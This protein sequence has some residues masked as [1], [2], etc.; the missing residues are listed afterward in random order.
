MRFR[1]PRASLVRK[2][3][4]AAL[5][6]LALAGCGEIRNTISPQPDTA[7][8]VTVALPGAPNAF[9][10][11]LYEAEARGYFKQSDLNVH[12]VVPTADPV[13][14]VHDGQALIGISSE[15][16]V[17]LHRNEDEPVVGV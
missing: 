8:N 16:N 5:T 15:P 4:V 14:M 1:R 9:Y 6:A 2:A 12:V 11:G 13:T 17:L 10:A 7:N 3:T